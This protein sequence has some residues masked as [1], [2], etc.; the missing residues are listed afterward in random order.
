M[1]GSTMRV[2]LAIS[3][4]CAAANAQPDWRGT[5][6]GY[7]AQPSS[8]NLADIQR[9]EYNVRLAAPYF[10][11]QSAAEYAANR[12]LMRQMVAYLGAVD[13]MAHD[14]PT[15][16]ALARAYYA[17]AA[18]RWTYPLGANW[19]PDSLTPPDPA[20]PGDP[21]FELHA[22]DMHDVSAGDKDTAQELRA[23]YVMSASSAARAWRNA[24]TIRIGLEGKGMTMNAQTA[25]SVARLQLYLE[26]AAAALRGRD[27]TEARE[28]LEKTE[29]EAE[30]VFRAVGR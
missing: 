1:E 5:L 12:V 24:E 8:V 22:P 17:L 26:L 9:L 13:L 23:R 16:A 11:T 4:F 18:L 20:K 19:A 3:L 21:P 29:Y 27:W 28:N 25:T 7:P 14:A 2:L 6:M 15:R 30:K 10:R